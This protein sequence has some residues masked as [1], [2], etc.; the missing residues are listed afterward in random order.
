M[1]TRGL[2]IVAIL[3]ISTSPLYAQGQQPDTAKLKADARNVVGIIGADK[4]KTQTY[5]QIV[6]L[7]EQIEQAVQGKDYK[8]FDELAQK[9]PELE[10]KL[11]P[12]YLGLLE[13]LRSVNLTSRDG[14]EIVSMFDTL[15]D[16]CPH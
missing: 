8:K 1:R 11:G 10:K 4:D 16:S 14:Q 12:E 7:G 6:D 2:L 13:S 9:L 3:A 5:C 15:G